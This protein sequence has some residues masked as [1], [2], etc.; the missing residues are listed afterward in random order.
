MIKG[1]VRIGENNGWK[2]LV[3]RRHRKGVDDTEL[4][5]SL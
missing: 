4:K 5:N 1:R 2:E 3:R